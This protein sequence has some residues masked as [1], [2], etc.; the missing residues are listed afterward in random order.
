MTPRIELGTLQ[1]RVNHTATGL[2]VGIVALVCM[3]SS[4]FIG[5][6]NAEKAIHAQAEVLSVNIA[7]AL[8]FGDTAA[9]NEMLASLRK[10]PDLRLAAL[11]DAKG[12]L[13]ANFHV[14][15]QAPAAREPDADARAAWL[16]S[17]AVVRPV[18]T[19]NGER[20]SLLLEV[21]MQDLYQQTA[22]QM[23]T[24]VLAGLLAF[25]VSRGQLRRLE[26]AISSP[27]GAISELMTD[28]SRHGD[29]GA[30]ALRSHITELDSLGQG[31][32]AMVEQLEERDLRLA[33]HRA[34]LEREM[35]ARTV[36]LRIAEEAT[37]LAEAANRAKSEFLAA[38]SHEVRTPMNGVLGMNELLLD[39]G[40]APQ[41]RAWAEAVQTSGQHLLGVINDILDFSKIESGQ[42]ALESVDFSLVETVEQALAMFA[43][44]AAAKGL[45]IAVE[46]VPPNAPLALR[47]DPFRLRQVLVNLLSNAIKFTARGEVVVRVTVLEQTPA[48]A[49]LQI[50]VCDTGIGIALENRER[51]FE[52]FAQADSS[53]TRKFGGTGLG[54]AISRRLLEL[55]QGRIRV[56]GAPG[57]GSTFIIDLELPRATQA[58]PAK[59]DSAPLRGVRVLVVDDNV[60][61]REILQRQ[62][63]G[64]RLE[65]SCAADGLRALGA[66][67]EAADEQRPFELAILDSRMPGMNGLELAE[68][69]HAYDTLRATRLVM[70]S[71][72]DASVPEST[73]AAAGIA[74]FV[75]KPARRDDLL[76]AMLTALAP[77]AGQPTPKP[78]TA[79]PARTL[80]GRVLLVEDNPVNQEVA[81]AMLA[82]L[83]LEWQVASDGAQA[84]ERVRHEDFDVVLMDCQ[85]P[86]MDGYEAT[87]AIRALPGA[88]GA[89]LP[90]VAVTANA[91][92]GEAQNC[93]AAGMDAYLTKPLFLDSLHTTLAHWLPAGTANAAAP[94]PAPTPRAAAASPDTE[95]INRRTIATLHELDEPGS[96]SLVTQLVTSFLATVE[97]NF[98]RMAAAIADDNAKTLGQIAHSQKS[99]AATLGAE[100]Y[101]RCCRD[102]E[103]CGREEQLDLART[104]LDPARLE[105]QRAVQ[106]LREM[107]KEAA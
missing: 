95:V 79:D 54:L 74:S 12:E 17:L 16:T 36:Q 61:N 57:Q 59:R 70:L 81:A 24:T 6:F 28:F 83:G 103:K 89:R 69:I 60:T 30:R 21:G 18:V 88:R 56:E 42:L 68:R 91:M 37:A 97:L 29:R 64:W 76:R 96:T 48:L 25:F 39:S 98:E 67:L 82:K 20:G 62:L 66:L 11:Y 92:P 72:T 101:A 33:E 7:A 93:L 104:L 71:S 80:H 23:A 73:R 8:A 5:V 3:A 47:G 31:F 44:P 105:L 26:Q 38:M 63:E 90:I 94:A 85:M 53:T 100:A 40:L 4:F 52:H 58:V 107:L 10:V 78:R 46:F 2:A 22:W 75:T 41:Q 50:R 14:G 9:A 35:A 13:F 99:S 43:Q 34:E 55:M 15:E 77:A 84:L 1:S 106:A 19:A 51:I 27:L 65:V 87:A 45:E 49:R 86:V 102:L 32:N